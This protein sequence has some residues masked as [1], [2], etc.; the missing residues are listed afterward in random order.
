MPAF[1]TVI[2]LL[3]WVAKRMDDVIQH[4]WSSIVVECWAKSNRPT[5]FRDYRLCHLSYHIFTS[6]WIIGYWKPWR[7]SDTPVCN[8]D[9]L[10]YLRWTIRIKCIYLYHYNIHCKKYTNF[11][12]HTTFEFE[13]TKG[14]STMS[15]LN[16][17]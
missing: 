1:T 9:I 2:K 14:N 17:N 7:H 6:V 16:L 10:I 4:C 15:K 5:M 3:S 8:C 12:W 11:R 13:L